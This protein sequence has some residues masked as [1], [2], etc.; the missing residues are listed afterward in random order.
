MRD[1][2]RQITPSD[3]VT[4][5]ILA[6]TLAVLTLLL[7]GHPELWDEWL[8]HAGALGAF[9]LA[10][11]FMARRSDWRYVHT[12]RAAT[13]VGVMFLLYLTLGMFPFTSIPWRGDPLLAGLD[14]ML[15]GGERPSVLVERTLNRHWIEFYSFIYSIFIPYLYFSI[16]LSCAGLPERQRRIFLNGYAITYAISFLGYLALPSHGP[17]LALS[18]EFAGQLQGG[19][20][21][22]TVQQGVDSVGGPHGAFPSLH[23]GASAFLCFFDLRYNRLRG[24]TYL[25]VMVLIAISTLVVRYHYFVDVATGLAIATLAVWLAARVDARWAGE[26]KDE[27]RVAVGH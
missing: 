4:G 1:V 16:F 13:T 23:V 26:K 20:F 24:L 5:G 15:F 27:G 22:L 6:V 8:T 11:W 9:A 19:Y 18:R 21:L 17:V 2:W 25:P 14:Q 12:L 7:P 10:A 3:W